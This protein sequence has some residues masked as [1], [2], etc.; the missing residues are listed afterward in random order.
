VWACA[1]WESH[2]YGRFLYF[3]SYFP[4]KT[5]IILLKY[6]TNIKKFILMKTKAI[7]LKL[8]SMFLLAILFISTQQLQAQ[9]TIGLQADPEIGALLDLKETTPNGTNSTA[10]KGLLHPRV[11]LTSKNNLFPMFESNG[12]GGYKIGNIPYTKTVEDSKHIGLVVYNVNASGDFLQ[13]LHIW[14]GV[15]WRRL[16]FSPVILPAITSLIGTSAIMTPSSYQANVYFN[17]ILKVPYIGGNGGT[18]LDTVPTLIGNNLSIERI[19]GKLAEGGGEVMYRIFGTPTYGSPSAVN[20]NIS[21]LGKTTAVSIGNSVSSLNLKNLTT[22]TLI[23]L[24]YEHS[25]HSRYP[26]SESN[27]LQFGEILITETGSYAFSLRLYGR[28]ASN[29]YSA[30]AE[31]RN[32]R[33]PFYIYLQK[34]DLANVLDAAEIDL[35]TGNALAT[36]SDYSYSVTLGGFFNAGERV[37]ISMQTSRSFTWN[38]VSSL[39]GTEPVRTSLIY[40]KL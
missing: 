28:I 4:E 11:V 9:V 22:A 31:L 39:D 33:L 24:P 16:D 30:T 38:L 19:A 21:F 3:T 32:L 13:G 15:E 25:D 14:D 29:P 26:A 7:K 17:G 1:F 8:L 12:T 36:Y 34:N 10:T 5:L 35:V 18:Y 20:F 2:L 6:L 23:N 27:T 40:W 37:L